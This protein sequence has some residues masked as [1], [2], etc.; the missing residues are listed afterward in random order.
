MYY[1][2]V[3]F[4]IWWMLYAFLYSPK[5]RIRRL[6]KEIYNI[7]IRIA[8]PKRNVPE[9]NNDGSDKCRAMLTSR[10][11]MIEAILEYNFDTETDKE[12]ITKIKEK[13]EFWE[14]QTD[15]VCHY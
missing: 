9:A 6:F 15:K 3:T 13:L 1:L 8:R 12:Y 11:K 5:A 4:L 10:Y 14:A 7:P 2:L